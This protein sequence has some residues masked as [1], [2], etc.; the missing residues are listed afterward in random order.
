MKRCK[1]NKEVNPKEVLQSFLKLQK[2]CIFDEI[3][4]RRQFVEFYEKL[5][6]DKQN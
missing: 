5:G 1:E 3:K 2:E 4:L 6:R